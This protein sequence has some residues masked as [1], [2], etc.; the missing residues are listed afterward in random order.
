MTNKPDTVLIS[1]SEVISVIQEGFREQLQDYLR[2]GWDISNM[3]SFLSYDYVRFIQGLLNEIFNGTSFEAT[4]ASTQILINDGLENNRAISIAHL[5]FT[6]LIDQINTFIPDV[7][8]NEDG[9]FY[10]LVDTG[11]DCDLM[12]NLSSLERHRSYEIDDTE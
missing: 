1:L 2:Y 8:F 12:V 6:M 9:F 10:N 11:Y 3:Q 5:V 7:N 4:P